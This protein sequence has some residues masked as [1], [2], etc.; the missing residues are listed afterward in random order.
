MQTH[1]QSDVQPKDV[2]EERGRGL[3]ITH[4]SGEVTYCT[5]P[6]FSAHKTVDSV[7]RGVRDLEKRKSRQMLELQTLTFPDCARPS[8]INVAFYLVAVS[9]YAPHHHVGEYQGYWFARAACD[10]LH[11]EFKGKL[12]RGRDSDIDRMGKWKNA[13]FKY[14]NPTRSIASEYNR[15]LEQYVT[16]R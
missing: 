5:D 9:G 14:T 11:S 4:T 12:K 7:H 8:V 10:G 1:R 6:F 16:V 13:S 2:P 15:Q 3:V